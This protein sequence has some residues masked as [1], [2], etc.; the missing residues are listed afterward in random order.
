MISVQYSTVQYSTAQYGT[1]RYG[2]VQYVVIVLQQ[3]TDGNGTPTV[4][5]CVHVLVRLTIDSVM[6]HM[7]NHCNE[8]YDW[9]L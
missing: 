5:C 2:T 6:R 1:V 3:C 4:C 9:P 7:I 8:T